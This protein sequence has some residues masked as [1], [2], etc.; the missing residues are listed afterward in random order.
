MM[1]YMESDGSLVWA[2]RTQAGIEVWL[3][4]LARVLILD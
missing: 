4:C 2:G 1:K 3:G